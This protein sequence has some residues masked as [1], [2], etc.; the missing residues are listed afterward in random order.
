[1]PEALDKIPEKLHFRHPVSFCYLR[2]QRQFL[3]TMIY[4]LGLIFVIYLIF[5]LNFAIKLNKSVTHLTDNQ[6]L[7][8]NILIWVIPFF[9]VIVLG[10]ILPPTPG[11]S[12][13]KK[14]RSNGGFYES[15]IG[16]WGAT[17]G[18]DHADGGHGDDGGHSGDG[19]D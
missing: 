12:K 15:G 14:G 10:S 19:G 1:M 4:F 13:S 16:I 2:R 18:H 7:L 5:T 9:W 6:L 3:I 17:D 11:S 8:H